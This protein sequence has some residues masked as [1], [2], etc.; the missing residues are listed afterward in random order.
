MD[1]STYSPGLHWLHHSK[2]SYGNPKFE[3]ADYAF[4]GS[5]FFKI[6]IH[7]LFT[8]YIGFWVNRFFL[9]MKLVTCSTFNWSGEVAVSNGPEMVHSTLE[10]A[11]ED[12]VCFFSIIAGSV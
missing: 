1:Y 9:G 7:G 2:N 8:I 6:N 11:N 4:T 5:E 3:A 10:H 12:L